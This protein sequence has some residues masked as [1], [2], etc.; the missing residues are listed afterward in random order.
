MESAFYT[1]IIMKP[2]NCQ[3][4]ILKM[5]ELIPE[6]KTE[7]IKDLQWNF[8]D[9]GYKSPED[10]LQ[11]GRTS[12]T[13]QKHIPEPSIEWEFEV[14]AVFTNKSMDEILSMVGRAE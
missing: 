2:R 4:V 9:A 7:L 14:L 11:W 6:E 5:I 1:Q 3:S 8:E 10:T 12:G 13:L